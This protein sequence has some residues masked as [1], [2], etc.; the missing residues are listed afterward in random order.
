MK[1]SSFA[2]ILALGGLVACQGEPRS[3]S[4]QSI[5]GGQTDPTLDAVV[6]VGHREGQ[7]MMCSGTLVTPDVVLTARHCVAVS[8]GQ[9]PKCPIDGEGTT[10]DTLH[11]AERIL[12][13]AADSLEDPTGHYLKV[14]EI[15]SL[16]NGA[17]RPICGADVVALVLAQPATI[18]AVAPLLDPAV[19]MGDA[20]TVVGFGES[21]PLD[22]KTSGTRKR[23]V[24]KVIHVG[25]RAANIFAGVMSMADDD[26]ALD[27]GP[28]GGDSGGPALNALGRLVGVMSRGNFGSCRNMVYTALAPH[29]DW[30]RAV[31]MDSSRRLQIAP[32]SWAPQPTDLGADT[33]PLTMDGGN[34]GDMQHD[35]STTPP[36]PP[37]GGGGCAV[38]ERPTPAWAT[39]LALILLGLCWRRR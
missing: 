6:L 5:I 30:L 18:A 12:V 38:G 19:A 4:S 1:K 10:L 14:A 39:T 9:G 24:A 16:P 8:P 28:C 37:S 33:L 17:T 31:G 26:F 15:L 36:A 34:V 7:G 35:G 11:A 3:S 22:D 13:Y 25:K 2:Y 20:I 21:S 32:P 23:S 27:Q 29:A